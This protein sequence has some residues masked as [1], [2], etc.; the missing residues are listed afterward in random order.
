[1][2]DQSVSNNNGN[3]HQ[4]S[5]THEKESNDGWTIET[6]QT[7][8]TEVVAS[9]SDLS[10]K[11]PHKTPHE[12]I[13]VEAIVKKWT[14]EES[15][16]KRSKEGK[17]KVMSTCGGKKKLMGGDF[18]VNKK[19]QVSTLAFCFEGPKDSPYERKTYGLSTAHL[20]PSRGAPI[21]AY[22]S[23]IADLHNQ[24]PVMLIGH[25]VH[26]APYSDS[27][28]F[29]FIPG[30]LVE[31]YTIRT[32]NETTQKIDLLAT[33]QGSQPL[34]EEGTIL[35]GFGAQRRGTLGKIFCLSGQ[36]ND[37]I[38]KGE[39][40]IVSYDQQE[41]EAIGS[42]GITHDGDCGMIYVDEYGIARGMHHA[43]SA[44]ED[45]QCFTSW[46]VPLE[47]VLRSHAKYFGFEVSDVSEEKSFQCSPQRS[48]LPRRVPP[49]HVLPKPR[50]GILFAPGE[51]PDIQEDVFFRPY[52]L[53]AF[54]RGIEWA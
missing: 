25:V 31:L 49:G 51:E 12:T 30:V 23:N 29:E 24:R 33:W 6:N 28:I 46:A 3:L 5:K 21:Y 26:F 48:T 34:P 8:V 32:S 42:K 1:M 20:A 27:L 43:A 44:R 17:D 45:G 11:T 39:Y 38:W 40:G 36:S 37:Y 22:T 47:R 35:L 16:D 54:T 41:L 9:F 4:G 7:D 53:N 52:K 50:V 14:P 13:D 15:R 10:L 19:G 2:D 18:I